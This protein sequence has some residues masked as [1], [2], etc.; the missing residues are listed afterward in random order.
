MSRVLVSLL[1]LSL[2][3][4]L[5]GCCAQGLMEEPEPVTPVEISTPEPATPKPEPASPLAK[6]L[7]EAQFSSLE[8][9]STDLGAAS[10]DAQFAAVYR[11]LKTLSDELE[12]AL[13]TEFDK[14][15]QTDLPGGLFDDFPFFEVQYGAE[16]TAVIVA[17]TYPPLLEAAGR[18]APKTDDQ[19]LDVVQAMFD[20]AAAEGWS[21]IEILDTDVTGCSPLGSNVHK[22][23]LVEADQALAEGDLFANE[24]QDIREQVLQ[25][26]TVGNEKYFPYCDSTTTTKTGNPKIHTE[27]DAILAEVDLSASER[28]QIETAKSE[29]FPILMRVRP[30]SGS[31]PRPKGR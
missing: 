13:Q 9:A 16:G 25:D 27:L 20:N 12:P 22:G 2:L 10:T 17:M 24:I 14:K 11:R 7:S 21:K 26:I 29:R 28:S 8:S 18:T 15:G 5:S 19:F 4:A 1:S 6:L 3:L 23:I 30:G 31:K